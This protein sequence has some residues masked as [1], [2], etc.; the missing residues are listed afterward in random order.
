MCLLIAKT[1][2]AT[3]IFFL[4]LITGF[5]PLKIIKHNTAFLVL[6]DAFASGV[7]LSA[8]LL[9]LLPDSV[10]TF[11]S[12]YGGTYPLPYFICIAT[13]VLLL[14]MER[15]LSIYSKN[16]LPNNKVM[17][18]IFLILLLTI[19]SLVEGAA[20]GANTNL[21][22]T[23]AIFFAVFAHKGS[24]SFALTV[25]LHR[26]SLPTKRIKQ[27]ISGFSFMTPIGIFIASWIIYASATDSGGVF[28]AI[29]DAI[30]A[31]TFLYLGMEHLVNSK[32]FFE[33]TSELVALIFGVTMMAVAAIWV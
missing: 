31:G 14:I 11:N 16:H 30:A 8:A 12:I 20:I 18:P 25:N 1:I 21:F 28:V 26:F 15:M 7:F 3:T 33:K 2:F 9:H 10:S 13:C 23:M 32:K 17:V 6:C 5:L 19:H 4:T 22:E 24:E 27:I 29:F